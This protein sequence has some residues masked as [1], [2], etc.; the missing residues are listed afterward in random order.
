[1]REPHVDASKSLPE[2]ASR[3]GLR[4]DIHFHGYDDAVLADL[5]ILDIQEGVPPIVELQNVFAIPPFCVLFDEQGQRIDIT[6][7]SY[8]PPEMYRARQYQMLMAKLH[9]KE[10]ARADL[11]AD[12]EVIGE[13]VFFAGM[14]ISHFGHFLTDGLS[15]F[16][17]DDRREIYDR[18]YY[19]GL[20]QDTPEAHGFTQLIL[21]S[22]GVALSRRLHVGR[23]AM[24]RSLIV[25]M[26][27]IQSD[28]RIYSCHPA[29]HRAAARAIIGDGDAGDEPVYLSRS[30]LSQDHRGANN[31][32]ELEA[33]FSRH[34]VRIVHPEMLGVADQIRLF[35]GRRKII[36][37]SG[38]ALHTIL[39]NMRRGAGSMLV[40]LTL[41]FIDMRYPLVDAIMLHESHYLNA[42]TLLPG[43][44]KARGRFLIDIDRVMEFLFERKI[45]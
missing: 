13:P 35:N 7:R 42:C 27:S 22:G 6:S 33:T 31:E 45:I 38:S 40:N 44:M 25:P 43:E 32:A 5:G 39:F 21:Q 41:P 15:R 20:H 17:C 12:V 29:F 16:W 19:Q 9:K 1:M 30:A 2:Q 36:S 37:C 26:P 18:F 24:F 10:P 8:R 4:P 28:R 14:F 34:G 11:P 3:A 23:P